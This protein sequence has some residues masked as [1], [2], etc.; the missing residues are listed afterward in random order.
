[1]ASLLM[2]LISLPGLGHLSI[3]WH[4]VGLLVHVGTPCYQDSSS[5][6]PIS[7]SLSDVLTQTRNGMSLIPVL[8]WAVPLGKYSTHLLSSFTECPSEGCGIHMQT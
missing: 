4:E 3:H 7:C 6:V 5:R 2:S 8:T 1:M